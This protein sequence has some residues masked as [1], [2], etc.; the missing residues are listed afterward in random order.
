M[1]RGAKCNAKRIWVP[2]DDNLEDELLPLVLGLKRTGHL[3][4]SIRIMRTSAA[5]E[6]KVGIRCTIPKACSSSILQDG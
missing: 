3:G 4:D 2:Q 5:E 1:V 6:V